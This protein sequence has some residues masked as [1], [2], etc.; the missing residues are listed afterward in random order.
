LSLLPTKDLRRKVIVE[1]KDLINPCPPDNA[2]QCPV[3]AIHWI[4]VGDLSLQMR[5]IIK[6]PERN[7]VCWNLALNP[8]QRTCSIP[9][10]SL[11]R[12]CP[13]IPLKGDDMPVH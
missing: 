7:Q 5:V 3:T 11:E 8:L 13:R 6:M 2:R 4:A 1:D 9:S 10:S 12:I